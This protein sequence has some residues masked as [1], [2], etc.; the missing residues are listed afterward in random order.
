M[1]HDRRFGA[2]I[3]QRHVGQQPGATICGRSSR[4]R[5]HRSRWRWRS[6]WRRHRSLWRFARATK[7]FD[8]AVGVLHLS[9]ILNGRRRHAALPIV[10]RKRLPVL[11]GVVADHGL[12]YATQ[13]VEVLGQIPG[14]RV[15]RLVRVFG[16]AQAEALR[17]GGHELHHADFAGRATRFRIEAGLNQRH[18]AQ[19][20]RIDAEL[21]ARAVESVR[22][23]I[24]RA[25][26]D[27][28]HRHATAHGSVPGQ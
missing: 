3:V 2:G 15:D 7:R 24:R 27:A 16:V 25:P 9:K 11:A 21:C 19:Q 10:S 17:G 23:S 4:W 12:L 14:S 22:E 13:R 5:R 8:L 18:R 28:L 6:L 1:R 26:I 20:V